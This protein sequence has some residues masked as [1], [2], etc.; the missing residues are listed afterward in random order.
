ME[1][2]ND[3]FSKFLTKNKN[4]L[5]T[6]SVNEAD[7]L[8]ALAKD[9]VNEQMPDILRHYYFYDYYPSCKFKIVDKK[10]ESVR[11][12]IWAFKNDK[13]YVSKTDNNKAIYFVANILASKLKET[14]GESLK[15]LT[16][17]CVPAST[18]K[19]TEDRYKNFCEYVCNL[20]GMINAYPYI[21]VIKDRQPS[22]NNKKDYYTTFFDERIVD[23]IDLDY[24][25]FKDKNVLLFDDV[26]TLGKAISNLKIYLEVCNANFIAAITIGKTIQYPHIV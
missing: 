8:R 1:D 19:I 21:K 26:L 11:K 2:V 9:W 16:F 6:D 15:K 10:A 23:E 22:H 5:E 4:H 18:A 25:F 3:I 24:E 17:V 13:R 7:F 20:T 12:L 14:F